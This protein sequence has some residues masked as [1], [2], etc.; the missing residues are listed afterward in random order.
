MGDKVLV[1]GYYTLTSKPKAS[2]SLF[3]TAT[4]GPGRSP[5]QPEQ[6]MAI[7][8]GQGQFELSETL[9]CDGYLHVT[10]YSDGGR[11]FGGFYFGTAQQMNEI[12]HWDV[13]RW[14]T[15]K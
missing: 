2:L 4:K 12:R 9:N 14:Y 15:S 11:P 10:F 1:K 7:T 6:T 3:A 5:I 8:E 13:R